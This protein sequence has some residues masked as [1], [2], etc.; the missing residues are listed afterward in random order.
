MYLTSDGHSIYAHQGDDQ[1]LDALRNGQMILALG[2]EG[3]VRN[4]D[5][6]IVELRGRPRSGGEAHAPQSV[7]QAERTLTA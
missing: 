1:V 5:S 6:Q 2:L 4:L 3:V 7:E